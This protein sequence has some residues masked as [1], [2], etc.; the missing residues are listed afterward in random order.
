MRVVVNS[1][2][3]M[4]PAM[5]PPSQRG[6]SRDRP[7]MSACGGSRNRSADITGVREQ[8]GVGVRMRTVVVGAGP[9]G[10][11]CAMAL[12]R[13]GDQVVVIDREVGPPAEGEWRRRGVMQ[14]AHPH[15]FRHIVRE[16]LT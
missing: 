13:Q 15:Y 5:V 11:Y 6:S 12:A 8:D 1:M 7:T 2:I 4:K 3:W 9:V 16:V 10:L 14:F